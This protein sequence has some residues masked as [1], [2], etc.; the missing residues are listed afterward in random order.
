MIN[1][2]DQFAMTAPAA[3]EGFMVD[4]ETKL[5]KPKC[6]TLPK[7]ISDEERKYLKDWV[8]D[9][10]WD[11]EPKFSEFEKAM[12]A[13]WSDKVDFQDAVSNERLAT[14]QAAWAYKYADAMIAEREKDS[15]NVILTQAEFAQIRAEIIDCKQQIQALLGARQ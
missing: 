12:K 3:P 14:K 6:P 2:R 15:G 8:E 9:P 5:Q 7:D 13:Y 4:Y 11:L 10:C 1:L